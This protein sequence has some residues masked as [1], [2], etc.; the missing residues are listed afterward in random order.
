MALSEKVDSLVF[1]STQTEA[2]PWLT[3]LPSKFLGTFLDNT[4]FKIAV[5]LRFGYDICVKYICGKI[6]V[7]D[8]S[9]R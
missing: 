7:S 5:A 9:H 6:V 3:V 4:T 2:S 8:G 1:L